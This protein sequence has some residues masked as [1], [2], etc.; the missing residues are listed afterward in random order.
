MVV[1][2]QVSV[3]ILERLDSFGCQQGIIDWDLLRRARREHGG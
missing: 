3:A 2:E 1:A